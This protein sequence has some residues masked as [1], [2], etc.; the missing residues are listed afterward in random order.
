VPPHDIPELGWRLDATAGS[1]RTVL[2]FSFSMGVGGRPRVRRG[3]G[4]R[5]KGI[6][7]GDSRELDLGGAVE[8]ISQSVVQP[9]GGPKQA[10]RLLFCERL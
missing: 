10:A 3:K 5:G 9:G 2:A 1:R 4:L 8:A 7:L 6:E